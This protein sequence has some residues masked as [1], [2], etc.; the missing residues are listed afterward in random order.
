M[1]AKFIAVCYCR[2]KT[3]APQLISFLFSSLSYAHRKLAPNCFVS[4]ST[5]AYPQQ[6]LF[7]ASNSI[8]KSE[9]LPARCLPESKLPTEL[10]L[11]I[12]S[13]LPRKNL[14]N[15]QRTFDTLPILLSSTLMERELNRKLKIFARRK[16]V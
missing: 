14:F 4:V 5:M 1:P 6:S 10:F 3:A 15:E 7:R 8:N 16:R 12:V 2:G 11:P 9:T 13:F